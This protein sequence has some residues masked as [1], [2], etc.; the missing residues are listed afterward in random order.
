MMGK[1][2]TLARGTQLSLMLLLVISSFNKSRCISQDWWSAENTIQ[3]GEKLALDELRQKKIIRLEDYIEDETDA[4]LYLAATDYESLQYADSL[5][6]LIIDGFVTNSWLRYV[7]GLKNLKTIGL[8]ATEVDCEVAK[9]LRRVP[10]LN[11]VDLRETWFGDR[12]LAVLSRNKSIR[13]LRLSGTLVTDLGIAQ[14][15]VD[16]QFDRLELEDTRITDRSAIRFSQLAQLH[17]INVSG[18]RLTVE[19]VRCLLGK[20]K[21]IELGYLLSRD[22]VDQLRSEFPNKE[23]VAYFH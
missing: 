4:V 14:I 7:V 3:A 13:E 23:I 22:Q 15:P 20:V 17:E 18:T 6:W 19:G 21:T 11:T 9:Y 1:T 16:H 12:G 2:K 8:A 10:A 5:E